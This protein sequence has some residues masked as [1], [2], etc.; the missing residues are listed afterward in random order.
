MWWASAPEPPSTGRGRCQAGCTVRTGTID[1]GRS[2]GPAAS[3]TGR[4]RRVAG[5]ATVMQGEAAQRG[6]AG[7]R[8]S[9]RDAS[10]LGRPSRRGQ[11]AAE[12]PSP[13]RGQVPEPASCCPKPLRKKGTGPDPGAPSP[14]TG[15]PSAHPSARRPWPATVRCTLRQFRVRPPAGRP[16]GQGR[17]NPRRVSQATRRSVP[18]PGAGR[19]R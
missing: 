13:R 3:E 14:G 2:R 16:D 15:V 5:R 19:S 4:T 1:S 10:P 6:L 11:A 12:V 18:S 17:V 9:A 7:A 8:R